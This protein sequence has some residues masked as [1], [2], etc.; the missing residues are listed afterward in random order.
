M[1]S[2]VTTNHGTS[3]TVRQQEP[4]E[5]A[6]NS[7]NSKET[8]LPEEVNNVNQNNDLYIS[9]YAY[10]E[11]PTKQTKSDGIKLKSCMTSEGLLI[12]GNQLWVS[13]NG[14]LWL[15]VIKEIHI[16]PVVGHPSIKQI[17]NMIQHNYHWPR[18]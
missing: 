2:T 18:M 4:H 7:K 8:T 15:K 17:L 16:Q 13:N 12:K 3:N 5:A 9:I 6:E 10:L 11:D 14:G 1:L